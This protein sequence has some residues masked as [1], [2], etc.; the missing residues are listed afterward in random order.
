MD[1]KPN[2]FIAGFAKSGTTALA[3]YLSQHPQ[4]FVPALKEPN[5][6]YHFDND[7]LWLNSSSLIIRYNIK[8]YNNLYKNKYD[9][10]YR[11]D[12]SVSYTYHK[13]VAKRIKEYNNS[14]IVIL[15]IRE[16]L[17]RIVSAYGYTYPFH[18]I[19]DINKWIETHL[20][21]QL[22][23]FLMYEKVVEY[24]KIFG[25]K[26][27]ILHNNDLRYDLQNTLTSLFYRLRLDPINIK[28]IET[29]IPITIRIN[30]KVIKK[31]FSSLGRNY[32]RGRVLAKSIGLE[33][34]YVKC[35]EPIRSLLIKLFSNTKNTKS[36][37]E[38]IPKDIAN[39]VNEDYINTVRY[40]TYNR[41][42]LK[43]KDN[44]A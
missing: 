25:N 43:H 17:Q 38:R 8:E 7:P 32:W 13:D 24:H 42:L 28:E 5:F 6:F 20:R 40:I 16:Q 11:V 41:L 21:P 44:Y 31:I 1:S 22:D 33:N 26:L 35:V 36:L 14:A 15:V 34:E 37:I 27:I 18:K 39:I 12:G 9:Y 4:I 19:D 3:E 2:L 23:T 29:N 30:N 10:K